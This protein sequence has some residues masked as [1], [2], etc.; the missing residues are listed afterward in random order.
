MGSSPPEP[1]AAIAKDAIYPYSYLYYHSL[2]YPR[3]T[4]SVI[5]DP[6]L[7]HANPITMS[8]ARHCPHE[9]NIQKFAN[10]QV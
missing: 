1:R 9:V 6:W 4:K 3:I 7:R 10:L 5:T 8:T 2:P